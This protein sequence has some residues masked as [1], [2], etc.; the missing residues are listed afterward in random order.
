MAP[1]LPPPLSLRDQRDED[2][3]FIEQLF[4]TSQGRTGEALLRL[5]EPGRSLLFAQQLQGQ[6]QSWLVRFGPQ[7]RKIIY[8][9]EARIGRLWTAQLGEDEMR[10]VELALV[11]QRR[12]QGLGAAILTALMERAQARSQRVSFR[13]TYDNPAQRL[14]RRLGFREVARDEVYLSFAWP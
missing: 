4:M 8:D 14:Y 9:G 1:P 10:I 3:P 11:P 12:G 5:P 6:E 2:A 7:G 13:T